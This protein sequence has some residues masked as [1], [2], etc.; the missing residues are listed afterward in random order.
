MLH[1]VYIKLWDCKRQCCKL[2]TLHCET[3]NALHNKQHHKLQKLYHII[4]IFCKFKMVSFFE[5]LKHFIWN[6]PKIGVM[7]SYKNHVIILFPLF[8]SPRLFLCSQRGKHI[9]ATLSVHLSIRHLLMGF[10]WNL[11]NRYMRG[12][13]V[14]KNHNPTM[15]IYWVVSP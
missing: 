12:S 11:A 1:I 7:P 2:C 13:V 15:D 4:R 8:W 6:F 14:H 10:K 5:C 9:V 3:V